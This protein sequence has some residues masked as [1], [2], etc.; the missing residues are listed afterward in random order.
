MRK[1]TF[2]FYAGDERIATG[3]D[4]RN[5]I[6]L[7][8]RIVIRQSSVTGGRVGQLAE[9]RITQIPEPS[10]VSVSVAL[11]VFMLALLRRYRYTR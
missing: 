10:I 5:D 3:L 11:L 2:D 9:I 4:W 6:D 8:D 1:G 7:I